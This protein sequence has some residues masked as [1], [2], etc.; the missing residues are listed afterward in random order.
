[1]F[2]S[3]EFSP[4]QVKSCRATH[5]CFPPFDFGLILMENRFPFDGGPSNACI[6][7]APFLSE[8]RALGFPIHL[9]GHLDW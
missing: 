4:A 8:S 1:M 5:Q 3:K 7:V 9:K 2:V 6:R